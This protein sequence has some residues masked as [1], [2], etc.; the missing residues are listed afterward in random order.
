MSSKDLLPSWH[1]TEPNCKQA[2]RGYCYCR[3][4]TSQMAHNHYNSALDGLHQRESHELQLERRLR[5]N[6]LKSD[7]V[8]ETSQA[9]DAARKDRARM[10]KHV[11]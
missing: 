7:A 9:L 3:T 1:V 6:D 2:D 11:Q 10:L 8:L 4:H 5:R